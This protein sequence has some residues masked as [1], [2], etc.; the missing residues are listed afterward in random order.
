LLQELQKKEAANFILALLVRFM[1][2]RKYANYRE[3]ACT[4][5]YVPYGNTKQIGEEIISDTAKVTGINS[6][7]LRYF[8]PIDASFSSNR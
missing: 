2:S 4:S 5:S 3:C 8:N 7:L 6:I 1:V